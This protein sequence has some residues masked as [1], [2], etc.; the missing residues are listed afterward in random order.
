MLFTITKK[1]GETILIEEK[2]VETIYCEIDKDKG[3]MYWIK[4]LVKVIEKTNAEGV[5]FN[6]KIRE[7]MLK[8]IT[9]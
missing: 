4:D 9:T 5:A 7:N 1:N 3:T 2:D 8:H 6:N